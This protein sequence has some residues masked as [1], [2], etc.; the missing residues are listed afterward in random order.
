MIGATSKL[1]S[2]KVALS[3]VRMEEEAPAEEKKDS[4]LPGGTPC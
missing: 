3:N 2:S 4:V 1:A